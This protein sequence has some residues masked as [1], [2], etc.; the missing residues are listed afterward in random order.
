MIWQIVSH[1][2]G[3]FCLQRHRKISLLLVWEPQIM[4]MSSKEQP[5]TLAHFAP[6]SGKWG[7]WWKKCRRSRFSPSTSVSPAKTVHSTNFSILTVTLGWYNRPVGA[8]V[9]C[10]PSLDST[11]PP[12]QYSNKKNNNKKLSCL[13]LYDSGYNRFESRPRNL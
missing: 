11:P 13:M 9:P 1:F 5:S 12:P 4:E 10:G 6:G 2:R 7:L 3:T 8:A